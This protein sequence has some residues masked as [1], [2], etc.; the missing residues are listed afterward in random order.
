MTTGEAVTPSKRR[1]PLAVAVARC[2]V[3]ALAGLVVGL[4]AAAGVEAQAFPNG[5]GESSGNGTRVLYQDRVL[6][7][8]MEMFE[9]LVESEEPYILVHIAES[10][11]LL[12]E[13]ADVVWSAPAGT[14]HG[15]ELEGAGQ[16]WTFTTPVGLFQVRRMEKDPV[17]Q[18][19][20]WYFV[21]NGMEPPPRNDPSR[22]I[23]STLGTTALFLGDGIAIHG[24]DQPELLMVDDPE[25]RRV[26]H[27]C[28]RLTDEAIRELF[29]KVS[30]GTPVVVF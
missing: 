25:E 23:D 4:V 21:Q 27:G 15:M 20:D 9:P 6:D 16:E 22:F 2:G 8:E 17:W 28:I 26:S 5:A 12:V 7:R 18:A 14:G 29:H 24:T 30:V 13:G 10:R 1:G 11:V 19:P 3:P